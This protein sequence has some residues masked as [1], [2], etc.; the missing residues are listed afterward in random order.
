MLLASYILL[1]HGGG[2]DK[3][4]SGFA[5]VTLNL[6]GSA[7]FLIALGMIYGTLG[8]LNLAD[9]A[10]QLQSVSAGEASLVRLAGALLFTVF[11]LKA[12]VL[13]L[14][15]WLPHAYAAAGAPV[16]ALFAIMTK[17]GIVAM[18]RVEMIAF[19][20]AAATQ[21]LLGDW[22]IIAALATIAVAA[23][24]ILTAK[25]IAISGSL[26]GAVFCGC[27]C[28]CA[29]TGQQRRH[30]RRTLLSGAIGHRRCCHFHALR[31]HSPVARPDRATSCLA[32][33]AVPV[34]LKT[35]LSAAGSH[36]CRLA[37]F[38]RLSSAN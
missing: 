18:L 7:V 25:K 21:D 15:F 3:S 20:P 34:K 26:A 38:L 11:L 31:P 1:A 35:W 12:A 37:A 27:C 19:D 36:R 4:R 17:V 30:R 6:A 10:M 29:T 22:L 14:S 2:L 32:L 13:P 16:A 33:Q 28:C 5:Y 9:I 24:G 8:T 23:L